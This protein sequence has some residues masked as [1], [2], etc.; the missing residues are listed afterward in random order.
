MIRQRKQTHGVHRS[1]SSAGLAKTAYGSTA[2]RQMEASICLH[3]KNL[4]G[5]PGG[6]DEVLVERVY[7]A[8]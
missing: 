2:T 3:D 7:P 5:I 4:G 8:T 1:Y 6:E